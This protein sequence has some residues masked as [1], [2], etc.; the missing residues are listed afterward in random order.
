MMPPDRASAFLQDA[1]SI[2]PWLAAAVVV[3]VALSSRVYVTRAPSNTLALDL[4][5]ARP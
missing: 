1:R 5:D 4:R 3:A 2:A